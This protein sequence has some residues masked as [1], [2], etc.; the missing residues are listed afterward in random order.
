MQQKIYCGS[1][2]EGSGDWSRP[3]KEYLH[4]M[5]FRLIFY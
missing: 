3:H 2:N 5:Y 1:R 4:D